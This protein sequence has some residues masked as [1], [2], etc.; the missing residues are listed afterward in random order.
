MQAAWYEAIGSAEEVLHVGKIDDP[1]PM[2]GE[3]LIEIKASGVNPSDVK[4][5]AGAR[6]ELQFPQIIPHSDGGG[7]IVEVGEG[8]SKDRIGERVWIWNGAFGRAYGTCAELMALPSSQAVTM[9]EDVSFETAACLGIPASTAYYGVFSDGSVENQTIL[10]TGGAGAVGYLGIQLAKWSGANVISTV[11]S[12]DKATVA[13]AAGAD[14]VVNYK[15]DDVIEAANDFTKGYGVDRILEVEF[16]G[17]LSVSEHV[18]KNNGVIAAYG[19]VA[20]ANPSLP[21]YNLMFKGVK[22]NTYLIYIVPEN[23][24]V[25]INKGITS[26]LSDNALTPIIAESF[27][28]SEIINAHQSLE[29]GSIIG[30]VVINI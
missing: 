19:S 14:L 8:V 30:N 12:D 3:V 10:I 26:A 21:F 18:I 22:L 23:D 25:D 15:T 9:S 17:N 5:R 20:E 27:N 7:I 6:G 28:L 13:K 24:R 1:S 29:E 2:E 11:S 4:T 16:G